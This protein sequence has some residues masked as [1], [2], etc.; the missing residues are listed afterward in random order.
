MPKMRL[1]KSRLTGKQAETPSVAD[2]TGMGEITLL[3]KAKALENLLNHAEDLKGTSYEE[4]FDYLAE[5][6]PWVMG[7]I[8][9]I[10]ANPTALFS[11]LLGKFQPSPKQYF[12]GPSKGYAVG[13]IELNPNMIEKALGGGPEV[14]AHEA[15]HAAQALRHGARKFG[16]QYQDFQDTVG[17][18]RNPFEIGANQVARKVKA[19]IKLRKAGK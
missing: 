17:Y 5:K 2:F 8:D 4:M 16:D 18:G 11:N 7:H 6:A 15:T 3:S 19:D 14:L 13:N 10:R 12:T 9:R 1:P